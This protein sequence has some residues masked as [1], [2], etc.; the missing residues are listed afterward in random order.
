MS[1][2]DTAP[3]LIALGAEVV[4]AS[5]GGASWLPLDELYHDD[6]MAYL[7]KRPDEMLT[8]VRVPPRWAGAAP[9]GSCGAVAASTSRWSRP[10]RRSGWGRGASWRR[11][12]SCSA[13]WPRARSL[14]RGRAGAGRAP[15]TDEVIA[16]FAE[17]ASRLAKPLDNTDFALGWRKRVTTALIAGALCELRGDGPAALGVLARH[18]HRELPLPVLQA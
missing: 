11:P 7:T 4:L 6:G 15:L 16:A 14:R 12:G 8:R 18:A 2:S 17:E 3:A 1:S 13:R 5:V 9:T 10:V